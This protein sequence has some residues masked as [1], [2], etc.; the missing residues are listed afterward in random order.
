[1]FTY[2]HF[3]EIQGLIIF[4]IRSRGEIC[5]QFFSFTFSFA[6]LRFFLCVDL[7]ITLTQIGLCHIIRMMGMNISK[8]TT[9]R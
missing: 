5:L 7:V 6:S 1:M 4:S 9:L 2:Q 8:P 3:Q